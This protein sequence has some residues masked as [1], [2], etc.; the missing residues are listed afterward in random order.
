MNDNYFIEGPSIVVYD[1]SGINPTYYK[2]PFKIFNS[3]T[4]K[5]LDNVYWSIAY[6]KENGQ[7]LNLEKEI[8]QEYKLS[9][10]FMPKLGDNNELIPSSMY[11][12]DG[13]STNIL[14]PVVL[15]KKWNSKESRMDTI[16][17]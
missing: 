7:G 12:G 15:C 4:K 1:S 14:Y 13:D 11:L 2:N 3:V 17:A 16:W 9:Y 10:N 5:E 6:Y 8:P